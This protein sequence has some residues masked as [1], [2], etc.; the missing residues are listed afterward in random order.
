MIWKAIHTL[1]LISIDFKRYQW[2]PMDSNVF[3]LMWMHFNEFQ[4]I[5]INFNRFQLIS[6]HFHWFRR[7]QCISIDF[8][9]FQ[10]TSP[11]PWCP[12]SHFNLFRLSLRCNEKYLDKF[13]VKLPSIVVFLMNSVMKKKYIADNQIHG[14]NH[15]RMQFDIGFVQIFP[16]AS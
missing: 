10:K 8:G 9:G 6:M 2:I 15:Y 13:H 4:T 14:K 11:A 16:I 7:F 3:H 1:Q 5:S 12:V